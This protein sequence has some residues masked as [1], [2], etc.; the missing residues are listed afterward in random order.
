[1]QQRR[2]DPAVLL[3][4]SS[5]SSCVRTANLMLSTSRNE[6]VE[7]QLNT[8]LDERNSIL[9]LQRCQT[10]SDIRECLEQSATTCPNVAAAALKRLTQLLH[11][12]QRDQTFSHDD[13][14][15]LW[16]V[17]LVPLE[18][19]LLEQQQQQQPRMNVGSTVDCLVALDLLQRRRR[20][21]PQSSSLR[22]TMA[23]LEEEK[24]NTLQ[25]ALYRQLE[26][27]Q[28]DNATVTN[29]LSTKQ[30]VYCLR[31][32]RSS[33][34]IWLRDEKSRT[35][36][37]QQPQLFSDICKRLRQGDSLGR[38]S[39]LD[40]VTILSAIA[41]SQQQQDTSRHPE[42]GLVV[43]VRLLLKAVSR[44]FR[45]KAFLEKAPSQSI[46]FG[47]GATRR[48]WS[49]SLL[50]D[51]EEEEQKEGIAVKDLRRELQVMAYT[52]IKHLLL[53]AEKGATSLTPLEAA[54]VC[55]TA[56]ELLD[57]NFDDP[58]IL[59]LCHYLEAS[60]WQRG[61]ANTI[62]LAQILSALVQ[63]Q[64]KDL[65]ALIHL[66]GEHF[67]TNVEQQLNGG[68]HPDPRD[69]NAILRSVAL[70][71]SVPTP[72][73]TAS[74]RLFLDR[75]FLKRCSASELSNFAWFAAFKANSYWHNDNRVRNT[76]AERILDSDV[77]DSCTPTEACRI[78]N[79]FTSLYGP[80][81]SPTGDETR[82]N[83]EDQES[84][85]LSSLFRNLGE[86]LLSTQLTPLDFSSAIYAYSKSSYIFD[87]GIFDHLVEL[88]ASRVSE[89]S[90]RQITQG[91][92]ACGRMAQW[93]KGE[94]D[95]EETRQPPYL[96]S[97]AELATYIAYHADELSA[98]DVAQSLWALARMQLRDAKLVDPL[99]DRAEELSGEFNSQEVANILWALSN[100][101]T[102]DLRAVFTLTRRFAEPMKE[103]ALKPQ[104]AANVLHA[105]GKMDVRDEVVF[106]HLSQQMLD[107]IDSTSAQAI[108]NAMWAHRAVYLEPPQRLLDTW[109]TQ[110][111]GVAVSLPDP[112][113]L[114]Y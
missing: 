22:E 29:T 63:W 21:R 42:A 19:A 107:Q 7:T 53:T 33:S 10:A 65:P 28:R 72:Y 109:A 74:T 75:D 91:L 35:S 95:D 76:L 102:K 81:T 31:A 87:I 37:S 84:L 2:H 44:K 8:T 82:T 90:F 12:R 103:N 79:A 16:P 101:K 45:K 108:A 64:Q 38:L 20:G 114:Y 9:A 43:E 24:L 105:M 62:V 26:G 25:H 39:A 70:L 41:S 61:A 106:R 59:S 15:G 23:L 58:L 40:L 93:E 51:S 68:H 47:L 66:L 55:Q 113:Y 5:S 13:L 73:L 110:K 112:D 18:T 78:L 86:H 34:S 50:Q 6:A 69:V 100:L 57:L 27:W 32:L 98:K 104:E 17:I 71:G 80:S 56:L 92:W 4:A 52:L 85:L 36:A 11:H 97:A 89:C 48:L 111:L 77:L 14:R 99:V 83:G 94:S 67:E 1:M 46:L 3:V 88:M 60:A 30:L 54:T 96:A 49:H